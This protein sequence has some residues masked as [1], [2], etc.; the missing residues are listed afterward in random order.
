MMLHG[1][2]GTGK[3]RT[4][5]SFVAALRRKVR[6]DADGAIQRARAS[7]RSV[8]DLVARREERLQ[9]GGCLPHPRAVLRFS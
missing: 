5:R 6:A 7:G 9:N 4:V 1:S 3:S 8:A 2:A